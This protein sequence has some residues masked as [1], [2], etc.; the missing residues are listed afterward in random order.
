MVRLKIG[1][2]EFEAQ[3]S[4]WAAW[5]YLEEFYG[6]EMDAHDWYE[7]WVRAVSGVKG[8]GRI[9]MMFLLRTAWAMVKCADDSAPGFEGWLRGLDCSCR[10]GD[11]WV[12]EVLGAISAEMFRQPGED[13]E[14][15]EGEQG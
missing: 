10:P 14:A 12:T 13:G 4:P 9:N 3:G 1:T 5:L 15:G 7:D 11:P 8:S 2:A 6:A